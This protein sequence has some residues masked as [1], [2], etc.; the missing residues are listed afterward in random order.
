M[1]AAVG[2]QVLGVALL[3]VQR[4]EQHTGPPELGV[5]D[6]CASVRGVGFMLL[7]QQQHLTL[8]TELFLV[9]R[10]AFKLFKPANNR[11][12]YFSEITP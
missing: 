4:S 6:R 3:V 12:I 5:G 1:R 11:S 2:E 9:L 10:Q 8:L 7:W